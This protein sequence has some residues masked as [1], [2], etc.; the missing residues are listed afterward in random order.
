MTPFAAAAIA[1]MVVVIAIIL[2]AAIIVNAH[3]I[4]GAFQ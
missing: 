1:Q 2:G 3:A 4:V